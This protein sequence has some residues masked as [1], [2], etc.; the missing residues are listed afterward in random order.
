MSR[1][2]WR[3]V[4]SLT[5][6][7]LNN[8]FSIA[9]QHLQFSEGHLFPINLHTHH[10][11]RLIRI[12]RNIDQLSFKAAPNPKTTLLAVIDHP[13]PS[14]PSSCPGIL[15]PKP[16]PT[17]PLHELEGHKH[18]TSSSTSHFDKPLDRFRLI[19]IDLLG[20]KRPSRIS[21]CEV[22][23]AYGRSRILQM[24][25]EDVR[26]A[27]VDMPG[28]WGEREFPSSIQFFQHDLLGTSREH[29]CQLGTI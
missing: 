24:N 8:T 27:G 3:S 14:D 22:S 20:K 28:L 26:I 4:S 10:P 6:S 18:Q 17:T 9:L 29:Y 16:P 12:N 7:H 1:F 19:N 25:L 5:N 11:S 21:S 13:P 15:A 23:M 2:G